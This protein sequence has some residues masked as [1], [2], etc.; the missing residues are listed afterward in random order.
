MT[1]GGLMV[2]APWV[3]F[4][5]SLIAISIRLFTRRHASLRH[6]ASGREHDQR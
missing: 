5:A 2:L 3:V 4:G 6:S 1:G